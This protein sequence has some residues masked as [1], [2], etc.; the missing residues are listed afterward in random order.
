MHMNSAAASY[1]HAGK[2]APFSVHLETSNV[3]HLEQFLCFVDTECY[4]TNMG[5]EGAENSVYYKE[6]ALRDTH[7]HK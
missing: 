7:V 4:P 2:I 5:G 1:V 6:E 3:S